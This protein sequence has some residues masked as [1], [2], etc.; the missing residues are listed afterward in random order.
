MLSWS[1][2]VEASLKAWA[3]KCYPYE[4]CAVL[5]G[6]FGQGGRKRVERVV[7]I[8]NVLH[9]RQNAGAAVLETAAAT[10]GKRVESRGEFEFVMD[11]KEFNRAALEAEKEGFDVVG[12]LHTHP[13]HPAK[14]SA[15]DAAQPCLAV[16]SNVIVKVDQGKFVEARSWVREEEDRPFQEE[17]IS[18]G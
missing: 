18:V 17:K 7:P 13:D 10:L 15:T 4:G 3:E 5:I 11:P 16:W 2:S 14:P 9:E 6:S 12:I 1:A 8:P